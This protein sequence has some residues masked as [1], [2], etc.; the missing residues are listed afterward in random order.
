MKQRILYITLSILLSHVSLLHAQNVVLNAQLDTF[1]IRI[2]EQTKVRLDLSVDAGHEVVM[3]Q[4]KD[5]T[6]VTGIEI[7]ELKEYNKETD[8][9][10]RK[11]YSQEY[12]ITSFDSTR[13]VIPPFNVLVDKD[14]FSSNKL[15]LDVYSVEID[16]ANIDN[17]AGPADIVDVELTWEEYRDAIYLGL[18]LVIIVIAFAWTTVRYIKNKPIIRI[19]KIKPKLPSHIVAI[20]KIDEIKQDVSIRT[21]GNEK[22]YY[23]R[24]TDILREYMHN[25]FGF[26]AREMTTAEI[27][28]EMLKI[29]EKEDI[30]ELKEIL[31]TAD[32]VKFAKMKPDER[33]NEH[34]MSTA[35]EFINVTKN[36]EE[37][38]TP[39]PTELKIKN[40]R[41]LTQK[42][43]LITGI[44]ALAIIL[45][46]LLFL[47]SVDLY[48]MFS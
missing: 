9:G 14:T 39:Q 11:R 22:E 18:L 43:L 40:E 26:D 17:I 23:T 7:L 10:K 48:N 15:V 44:I 38:K 16:T 45:A 13:Y 29:K 8:N 12:L 20:N 24:L 1:A 33:E 28:A 25:R 6:L 47:L 46:V 3:P 2:G 35:I 27:V 34:N 4:M 32:L 41:S 42:L 30:K 19:V 31:E 36:I 37:E 5:S 21:E